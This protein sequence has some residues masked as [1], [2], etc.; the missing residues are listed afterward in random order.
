MKTRIPSK[1]QSSGISHLTFGF[2]CDLFPTLAC[3]FQVQSIRTKTHFRFIV[4]T[5]NNRL[6]RNYPHVLKYA[7]IHP[8]FEPDLLSKPRQVDFTLDTIVELDP[9]LVTVERLNGNG[10]RLHVDN[11]LLKQ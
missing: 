8:R 3:Q 9:D 10:S 1:R 6:V 7:A 11:K 5:P 2:L 4:I